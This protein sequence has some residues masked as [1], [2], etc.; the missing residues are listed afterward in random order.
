V[1]GELAAL[2]DAVA[3]GPRAVAAP[4]DAALQGPGVGGVQ[5]AA[6]H[7]QQVVV[8]GL[9]DQ[10][11]AEDVGV[12]L[13]DGQHVAGHRLAQQP[14]QLIGL[15]LDHGGQQ[16]VVDAAAGH[17]RHLQHPLG[18]LRERL[19]PGQDHVPQGRRQPGAVQVGGQQLLGEE[20]VALGAAQD[21][22]DQGGG[23]RLLQ[24]R[25]QQLGQLPAAQSV[26]LQPL[27]PAAAV[28]LGQERPQRVAAVQLVAAV[29][30]HQGHAAAQVADQEAQQVAD[31]LVGPVQVLHHQQHRA[32]LGEAVQHP[33]QQLEQPRGGQRRLRRPATVGRAELGHQPDQLPAGPAQDP[34]QLAGVEDADQ[35]P[36][37]LHHRRVG[38]DAL[39]D[40]QAAAAEGDG[41]PLAGPAEQLGHQPGLADAGLARHHHDGGPAGRGP[42]ERGVEPRDLGG[43][44]DQNRTGDSPRHATDHPRSRFTLSG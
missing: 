21:L 37:R 42:L 19:H 3:A 29:G 9:L 10:G 28:Q 16:L 41:A 7:R 18:R 1:V 39:A 26:Q 12:G 15:L 38:E 22:R 43:P 20:R 25:G 34:L 24:D 13:V 30:E 4:L 36:Q 5:G 27:G 35:R 40:V 17:R 6:L 8:D 14:H 2:D 44:A 11:V 32:A 23:G 31:G 33:E